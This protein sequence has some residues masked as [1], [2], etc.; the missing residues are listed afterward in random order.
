MRIRLTALLL[1]VLVTCASC[2]LL[3]SDEEKMIRNAWQQIGPYSTPS[4][5]YMM[6][7][8]SREHLSDEELE[9]SMYYQLPSSGYAVIYA[10]PDDMA[11]FNGQH[12]VFL[13]DEGEVLFH[14]DYSR[15]YQLYAA[16]PIY[17]VSIYNTEPLDRA[18]RYLTECNYFAGMKN[19]A[20]R[21]S[22]QHRGERLC[23]EANVWYMLDE[24]KLPWVL[25]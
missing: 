8:T 19:H 2:V 4:D 5:V 25:R 13:N 16:V 9:T 21:I 6:R 23:G 24:E 20:Y 22:Y 14:F 15:Q 7:Y 3:L 18:T 17:S 12:T 10:A 1:A 11:G